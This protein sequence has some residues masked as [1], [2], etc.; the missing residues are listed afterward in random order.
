MTTTITMAAAALPPWR[1]CCPR[2]TGVTRPCSSP[3]ARLGGWCRSLDAGMARQ[4]GVRGAR[5]GIVLLGEQSQALLVS[6]LTVRPTVADSTSFPQIGPFPGAD[7]SRPTADQSTTTPLL[8]GTWPARRRRMT[9]LVSSG[10]RAARSPRNSRRT[11]RLRGV[12]ATSRMTH[13]GASRQPSSARSALQGL[14]VV[15][16]GVCL[17]FAVPMIASSCP[18]QVRRS[19]PAAAAPRYAA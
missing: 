1:V 7:R 12:S 4:V 15:Q 17:Q 13:L 2:C 11:R 9:A 8:S 16:H 6:G 18:S 3:G 10:K 19:P 5:R 14:D